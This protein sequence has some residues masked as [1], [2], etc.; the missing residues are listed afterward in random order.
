MNPY[1]FYRNVKTEIPSQIRRESGHPQWRMPGEGNG[2]QDA[3]RH[4]LLA[5]ELTRVH[6]EVRARV[7]LAYHEEVSGRVHGQS[8]EQRA[9]DY[10]NNEIGIGIG[11]NSRSW[12]DVVNASRRAIDNALEAGHDTGAP[13]VPTWRPES[14]WSPEPSINW[15]DPQWPNGAVPLNPDLPVPPEGNW[16]DRPLPGTME[17]EGWTLD[18][19]ANSHWRDALQPRPRDPL[20]IDL[21][22]IFH[23]YRTGWVSRAV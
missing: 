17:I 10:H 16:L 4:M 12:Q 18:P 7:M 1:Q 22:R 23:E 20:A 2:P 5:A 14:E 3:Y 15:P 6:G 21:A 9:M 11:R 8:P 19:L 13:T